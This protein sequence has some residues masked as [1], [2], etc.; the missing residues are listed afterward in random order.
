MRWDGEGKLHKEKQFILLY[1][2]ERD[3]MHIPTQL[4]LAQSNETIFFSGG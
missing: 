4:S 3:F 2:M 1:D